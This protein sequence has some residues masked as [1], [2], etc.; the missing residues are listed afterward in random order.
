MAE[1]EA[2]KVKVDVI[3]T[4]PCS[5]TLNIE[6][7]HSEVISET[8]EVYR[9]LQGMAQ[10]PGFRQGKAPM[11]LVKRNYTTTAKEKVIENL[12]QQTVF[13]SLKAH[14]VE[15]I[16]Y[17]LIEQVNFDFDKPF[18]YRMKAERHPEFK[19]KDYKKI[20][21]NKEIREIT[22]TVVGKRIDALRERN[23]RLE[24]SKSGQVTATSFAIVDFDAFVDG[25]SVPELKAKN[26]LFDLSSPQSFKGFNE[27]IIGMKKGE[28][29]EIVIKMPQE[30]PNK[31]IAGK[32]VTFK[33]R[34]NE[35]KEKLLPELD[36]ELAKDLGVAN[37]QELKDK[38]K[39][40]MIAEEKKHEEEE[41][42]KQ[43][44]EHLLCNNAFP[45][46][47]SLTEEQLDYI[48]KRTETHYVGQGGQ[49]A[50]WDKKAVEMR[51][52]YREEAEKNVRLSYILNAVAQEEKLE[53]SEADIAKEL[54]RVLQANPGKE[55]EV[56]KYFDENKSSIS[57]RIKEQKIFEF[58]IK[59]ASLKEMKAKEEK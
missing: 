23:A 41:V 21:I 9:K 25:E 53:V 1:K 52:K 11:D 6:V 14:G 46:P 13:S 17:P 29:K 31:K 15:P 43:I 30:Y 57:S 27:G 48:M 39:E 4:K 2:Q 55:E 18:S 22:D 5:V 26:Q 37:L 19:V 32:D 50:E 10:V 8:E 58:L 44:I 28:E 40:V 34:V 36:D 45:V 24:E 33:A 38:V 42:D 12:I 35:I 51:P 47:D 20:K 7:P 16:N 49:K 3:D 54:D 56:K 59:E